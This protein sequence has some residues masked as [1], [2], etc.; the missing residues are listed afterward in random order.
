MKEVH[1]VIWFNGEVVKVV[2]DYGNN[3]ILVTG[4]GYVV[5]Y[6]YEMDVVE[7]SLTRLWY[8]ISAY[9]DSAIENTL[10]MIEFIFKHGTLISE[11]VVE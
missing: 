8:G 3:T 1:Y 6:D 2:I 9:N 5:E 4:P 10:S 11:E 7:V